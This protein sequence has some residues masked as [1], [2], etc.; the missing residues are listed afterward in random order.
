MKR[1]ENPVAVALFVAAL[2]ALSGCGG[3]DGAGEGEPEAASGGTRVIQHALGETEVPENPQRVVAFFSA[4]D[5]ALAVGVKPIA[6]DDATANAE[7]LQ[8]RLEGV[9]NVGQAFEPNLEEIAALE[10]DLILALDVV[11]EQVYDELN[12]IAPTVGVRFGD[13]SGEWERYNRRYAEVLNKGEEFDE[14]MAD[15]EAK[16]QDF[17][18]AMGEKLDETKVAIMRASPENLRF[19]LPGIFIGDVVYNDA[20]LS[21]PPRLVEPAENPENYT[22]EIS[23]E[24]FGLAEGADALFVW[25]VTGVSAENDRREIEEIMSDPV[26]RRLEVVQ[27][28]NVYTMGDHWFSESLLGAGMVLDD[29]EKYLVRRE[30]GDT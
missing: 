18:E 6:V 28:G 11:I 22:L 8:D 27:E 25:N 15:Y 1:R 20:G 16:A 12:Q 7:Y 14:V 17:Q 21:L 9:E 4:A 2:V 29:L 3:S 13:S 23:R 24:Q 19:D 30:R 5:V 26:F 10:P